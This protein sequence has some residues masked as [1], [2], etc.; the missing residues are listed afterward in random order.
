MISRFGSLK[1]ESVASP[2]LRRVWRHATL[3]LV[4][5]TVTDADRFSGAQGK[6]TYDSMNKARIVLA[7]DVEWVRRLT[8]LLLFPYFEIVAMVSD[9]EAAIDAVARLK[10]DVLVLDIV[11][12]LLDGLK[13]AE[14]LREVGSTTKVVF[15]TGYEDDSCVESAMKTGASGFVFKSLLVADLPRAIRAALEGKTFISSRT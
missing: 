6:M 1:I 4:E 2:F 14:H 7:D 11:M 8:N 15:L 12:P 5:P 10:P 13:T 3:V 9:G